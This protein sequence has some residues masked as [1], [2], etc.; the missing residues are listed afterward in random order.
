MRVSKPF[1]LFSFLQNADL[2]VIERGV[3]DIKQLAV[4]MGRQ[5]TV[6]DELIFNIQQKADCTE[7]KMQT[8]NAKLKATLRKVMDIDKFIVNVVLIVILLSLAFFIYTYLKQVLH[9]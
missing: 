4:D 9:F 8:M 2:D 7:A 3:C 5:L 6:H 1:P